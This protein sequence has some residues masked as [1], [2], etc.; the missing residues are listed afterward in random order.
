MYKLNEGPSRI[1]A[2]EEA[3]A[4]PFPFAPAA[5]LAAVGCRRNARNAACFKSLSRLTPSQPSVGCWF[6]YCLAGVL[7][8]DFQG[9]WFLLFVRAVAGGFGAACLAVSGPSLR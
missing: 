3:L 1:R 4:N 9:R 8:L 5:S 7:V 2:L 6:P